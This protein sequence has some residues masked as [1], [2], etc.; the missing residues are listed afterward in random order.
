[1]D[2]IEK[3]LA[4]INLK[5]HDIEVCREPCVLRLHK[6]LKIVPEAKIEFKEE[7]ELIMEVEE[8]EEGTQMIHQDLN[9]ID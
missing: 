4:R 8:V 5:I 9:L 2:D 6:L 1:L 3:V 7:Q